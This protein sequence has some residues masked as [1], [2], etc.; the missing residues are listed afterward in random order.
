VAADREDVYAMF[1]VLRD[2]RKQAA[3]TLSGGEQQMLAIGRALMARPGALLLDEPGMGL[4][5]TV[6]REI[7]RHIVKLR[8]E[9]GLTVLLVEQ[10]AKNAL[11]VADRAYVSGDRAHPAQG[12]S[13]ELSANRDVQRAYLGREKK[14]RSRPRFGFRI[15]KAPCHVS[16]GQGSHSRTTPTDHTAG[17]GHEHRDGDQ[18]AALEF[19]GDDERV[20]GVFVGLYPEG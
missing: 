1:P 11:A 12:T 13:E 9:R 4:A 10:N 14:T 3:G 2:R 18:G 19:S 17:G 15:A 16:P 8:D 6:C 5:P 7:F 20:C